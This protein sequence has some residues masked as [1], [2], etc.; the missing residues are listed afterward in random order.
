MEPIHWNIEG[1]TCS[2]CALSIKKYLESEGA[3]HI[4]VNPIS[5]K[6][7]FEDIEETQLNK[8]ESGIRSLGYQVIHE[9]KSIPPKKNWLGT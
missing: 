7:S 8:I 3:S 2:N 1:M 4:N 6:L 9:G 5:G